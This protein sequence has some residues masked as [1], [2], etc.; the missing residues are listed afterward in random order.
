MQRVHAIALYCCFYFLSNV[1]HRNITLNS[2]GYFSVFF[3]LSRF[4]F[5]YA[6]FHF[7]MFDNQTNE[8]ENGVLEK[9]ME[10]DQQ[11]DSN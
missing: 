10:L 9:I 3:I 6:V 5:V 1:V 7:S 8:F 2:V 4:V 11:I